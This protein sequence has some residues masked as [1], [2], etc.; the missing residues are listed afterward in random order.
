CSDMTRT[1]CVGKANA[2]QREIYDLVLKA[3]TTVIDNL[4]PGMKGKEYDK[5]ARD[6]I[7]NAGYGEYF[8]HGLGHSV[9]LEIHEDPRFSVSEERIIEAGTIITVEPGI[10]IPDFGGVRI[11]DML[12]LTEDGCEDFAHSRKDFIEL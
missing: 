8:G 6:I 10:Y 12:V 2:K 11:E 3:Q 4:K 7:A 9:G 1:V 5:I